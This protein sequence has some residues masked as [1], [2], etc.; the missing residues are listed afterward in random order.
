[1]LLCFLIWISFCVFPLVIQLENLV[2]LVNA[3]FKKQGRKFKKDE[4][5]VAYPIDVYV[6]IF[7]FYEE[8]TRT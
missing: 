7:K 1:M 6:R 8:K 2:D 4:L 3:V 5:I